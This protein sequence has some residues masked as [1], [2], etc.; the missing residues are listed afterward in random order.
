MRVFSLL[1]PSR[2]NRVTKK[3]QDTGEDKNK[4][5]SKIN[6]VGVLT[7]MVEEQMLQNWELAVA[8]AW[9]HL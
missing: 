1:P 9:P 2:K 5:D 6:H 3:H 4:Q 7:Q 8:W